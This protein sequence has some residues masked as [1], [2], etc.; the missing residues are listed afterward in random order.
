MVSFEL[1]HLDVVWT[2]MWVVNLSGTVQK[3]PKRSKK[4]QKGQKGPKRSQ[5][6]QKGPKGPKRSLRSKKA[7]KGP[8]GPK[9]PKKG[10]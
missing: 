10:P 7:Q 5:I 3:G 4:V 1:S 9:R 2:K 8:I 6:V